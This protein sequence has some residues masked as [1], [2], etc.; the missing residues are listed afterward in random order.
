M[1]AHKYNLKAL[2]AVLVA[3]FGITTTTAT[4]QVPGDFNG[5]GSIG[6]HRPQP[7]TQL[8]AAVRT[9]IADM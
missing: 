7:D 4:A 6:G 3:T 2:V 8:P 5:D 1:G 9:D